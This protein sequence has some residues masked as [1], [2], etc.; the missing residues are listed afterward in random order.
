MQVRTIFTFPEAL[1]T[2]VQMGPST[3]DP[4]TQGRSQG[5]AKGGTA[6]AKPTVPPR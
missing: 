5:G 6:P 1:G 2:P 4:P 3:W